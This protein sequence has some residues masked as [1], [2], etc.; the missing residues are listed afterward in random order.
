[1]IKKSLLYFRNINLDNSNYKY[2]NKFFIIKS[3]NKPS[4]IKLLSLYEKKKIFCIYCDPKFFYSK[5]ILKNFEKLEY[6]ISSTTGTSFIDKKYCKLK[7]IKIISL[8]KDTK[9]LSK[10]TPTAEHTFGLLLTLIRNYIPA[11]KAVN[12]G[13]F[14]R[15][16]FGGYSMLS[17]LKLGIIGMGRLGKIVK[18]IALGFSMEVIDCDKKSKKFKSKLK[19]NL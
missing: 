1:M 9:F 18:K 11:I 17:R 6:L 8:E 13:K 15:R 14:N 4:E 5:K 19:K 3:I 2:L 10:I 7:K 12:K 16:P